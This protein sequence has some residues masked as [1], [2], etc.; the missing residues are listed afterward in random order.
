MANFN[1]AYI[2]VMKPA[3]GYTLGA[4]E[5]YRGICR[6][7]NPDWAGWVIVDRI[8]GKKPWIRTK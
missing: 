4:T 2:E 6:Q 5:K 1:T 3:G 7:K 8:S